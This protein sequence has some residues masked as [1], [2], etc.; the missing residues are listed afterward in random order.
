MAARKRSR[1]KKT[2]HKRKAPAR[3]TKFQRFLMKE[4]PDAIKKVP[5]WKHLSR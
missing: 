2:S 1:K 3:P 5:A 4:G